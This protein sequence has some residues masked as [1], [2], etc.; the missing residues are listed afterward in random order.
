[1]TVTT[2]ILALIVI[3]NGIFAV[4]FVMDVMKN[5][6]E[7][8]KEK[9]NNLFLAISSPIIFF[10]SSFG[11]SDFAVS[12]IL[13]RKKKLVSDK[14]LPGTLNTQCVIPVAVTALAFISV[15][16]VDILTLAV[17]IIA[18]IIGAYIGPRFV[19]KLSAKAIRRFISVGLIIATF[20]ILAGKF[21]WIPSG[22]TATGLSGGKL[23]IAAV[24]LFVFGALNNIGIGSYALTMVT[25]YALGM[26]P[27]VAF[28]IMMG[29]CTFSVPIGSMEFIKYGQ[30]SRKITLFTSTFGVIGVLVGVYLVKGLD[31]SMLQ[32]VVAAILLYSGV[33]ML[34]NEIKAAK[35]EKNGDQHPTAA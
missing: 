11:V 17:C 31:V 6:D 12:T 33:S 13:Y 3:V 1:M 7:L 28:P 29:A 25:I 26:N 23:V 21:N 8:K 18:Q 14:M 27:A 10:F 35:A 30:Y 16:K 22:G 34:I 9:G 15:I 5:K 20:F 2:L 32:W 4:R 24:C 19:V